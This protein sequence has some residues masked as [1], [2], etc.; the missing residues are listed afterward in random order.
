MKTTATRLL[1]ALTAGLA[2]SFGAASVLAA[3][4]AGKIPGSK[5]DLSPAGAGSSLFTATND[6]TIGTEICVFC[7]TPHGA[8]DPATY[9]LPLW[10]RANS[11]TVFTVYSSS[12]MEGTSNLNTAGT[13][14]TASLACLSCH[15]GATA[16]NTMVNAP[17]S[18]AGG[19]TY[20]GTWS[21]GTGAMPA[22]FA[23]LG[24]DLTNDHPISIPYCGGG[25]VDTGTAGPAAPTTTGPCLDTDFWVTG[26]GT[27][28]TTTNTGGQ[29]LTKTV[30]SKQSFWVERTGNTTRNKQ[31]IALYTRVSGA[32]NTPWV[33]CA[34]CHDPH[35]TSVTTGLVSFLRDTNAGS[36][37][38]L[39][40]HNK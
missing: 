28:N 36:Q 12:T 18:G 2:L 37:I 39:T 6:G 19:G 24:S 15:D 14:A 25:I 30:G 1:M 20:A 22:V 9:G 23:N 21:S 4:A 40:C 3:P 38:C 26:G 33:E 17:G 34:S 31:D 8:Q 16:R 35:N 13:D 10:N 27:V 7:H 11:A 5:H 32:N 29:V